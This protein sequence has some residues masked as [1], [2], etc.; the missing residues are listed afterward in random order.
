ML[1]QVYGPRIYKIPKRNVRREWDRGEHGTM[2][3]QGGLSVCIF[4]R[5]MNNM[6]KSHMQRLCT[7]HDL[8]KLPNSTESSY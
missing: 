7:F 2:R 1:F 3:E 6:T 8:L 5:W 4:H